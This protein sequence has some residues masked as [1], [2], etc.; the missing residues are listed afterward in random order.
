M[1]VE[2]KGWDSLF[3]PS[4]IAV[5]GASPDLFKPGGNVLANIRAGGFKGAVFPVNPKHTEI[6]GWRCFP[7]LASVPGPVD[8][9]IIAV[10]SPQVI[11]ALQE[12]AAR[13]TGA[14]IVFSS[15]FGEVDEAGLEHQQE[16]KELA[17]RLDIR[18]CGPNT[19]GIINY[20]HG[21]QAAF[22]YGYTLPSWAVTNETGIAL[23]CQSGG[24]GCSILEACAASG[25]EVAI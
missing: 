19:M 3:Y 5:V 4:S 18:V 2:K 24:V 15:G 16:I 11:P 21:M 25:L 10:K 14:V 20:L 23:I 13:G 6:N 1:T 12:C 17:E 8:L 9:A 22:V 7:D